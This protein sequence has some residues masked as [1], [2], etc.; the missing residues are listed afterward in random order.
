MFII[1]RHI[2]DAPVNFCASVLEQTKLS[3]QY[4]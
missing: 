2:Q 1:S 4:Y 3:Y